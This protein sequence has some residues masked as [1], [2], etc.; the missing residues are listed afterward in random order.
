MSDEIK[1]A[2]KVV[3]TFGERMNGYGVATWLWVT[4]IS[5]AGGLSSF[6]A[7]VKRGD[8]RPFNLVELIGELFMSGTVGWITFLLCDGYGMDPALSGAVIGITSH[9]GSRA[10]YRAEKLLAAWVEKRFGVRIE[11]DP[12]ENGV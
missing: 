5:L 4:A 12:N 8:A 3:E 10:L 6:F 9:M 11:D 7:K 2:V 1:T